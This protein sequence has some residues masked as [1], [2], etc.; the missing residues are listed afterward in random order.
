MYI[1]PEMARLLAQAKIE[2]AQSRMPPAPVRRAALLAQPR[3]AVAFRSLV[4]RH[5]R[6]A[7]MPRGGA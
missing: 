4:R 6:A 1:H 7:P 2:E 5:R 3:R